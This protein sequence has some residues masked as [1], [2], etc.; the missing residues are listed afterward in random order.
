MNDRS[1]N[2]RGGRVSGLLLALTIVAGSLAGCALNPFHSTPKP[3]PKIPGQRVSVLSF[4]TKLQPDERLASLEVTLP[5]ATENADWVQAGG[6]PTHSMGNLAG[7]SSLKEVWHINIGRGGDQGSRVVTPPVV[8]QGKVIA[9]DNMV[10]LSAYDAKTGKGLWRTNLAVS[11]EDPETGFGGGA[12]YDDGKLFVS[13]GFGDVFAINPA[14]GAIL[15]RAKTGDPFRSPPTAADGRVYVNSVENSLYA[16]DQKDGAVLWNYHAIAEGAHILS[17]TTPAASG[18]VVVAPFTSGELTAFLASNGRQTWTDSLTRTGRQSSITTL[19]DIAGAPVIDGGWV[20]AVGHAGR[21]VAI[22]LRSGQRVWST[23]IASTQTPWVAGDFVYVVTSDAEVLCIYRRDGGIKWLTPL[24]AFSDSGNKKPIVWSG[25]IL[26]GG[27][28]I[29][30]SSKHRGQII[31]AITGKALSDFRID[32][33]V[34]G[35]PVAAGGMI[36][37]VTNGGNL[38]AYGDPSLRKAARPSDPKTR[39]V[40]KPEPGELPKIKRSIWH[41]P[42]WIPFL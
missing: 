27:K 39:H 13:T 2:G 30:V 11:I 34:F 15:W 3:K 38:I 16:L 12:A 20:F 36:Y 37:M 23:E 35:P 40:A 9:L 18:D 42:G 29:L 6:N 33:Q 24:K 4:D 25:P 28:L 8:V 1:V 26:V 5:A 41:I 19:N 14:D 31:D 7:P 21:M 32:D 17:S 10:R 22:D